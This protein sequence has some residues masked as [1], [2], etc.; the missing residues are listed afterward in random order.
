MNKRVTEE[1]FWLMVDKSGGP[2]SC[3]IWN[4]Y[5][6]RLGYGRVVVEGKRWLAHRYAYWSVNKKLTEAI[7]HQ[8]DNLSCCNPKHL[9]A[10]TRD[11]N[12]K[13]RV[14]KKRSACVKGEN[15]HFSILK[16]QDV[17]DIRQSSLTREDLAKKYGVHKNTI[18]DVLIRK[19]WNHI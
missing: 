9:I 15:G 12:N 10:A 17:L 14:R 3:W 18:R 4:G 8:C 13:D 5:K 19:S 6:Q 7:C 11:F 2:D 16:N 1:S